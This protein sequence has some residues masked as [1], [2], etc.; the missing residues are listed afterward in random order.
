[1]TLPQISTVLQ[2]AVKIQRDCHCHTEKGVW[3][4]PNALAKILCNK[5]NNCLGG[6]SFQVHWSGQVQ[7]GEKGCDLYLGLVSPVRTFLPPQY[8]H[9]GEEPGTRTCLCYNIHTFCYSSSRAYTLHRFHLRYVVIIVVAVMMPQSPVFWSNDAVVVFASH[10]YRSWKGCSS[11][12]LPMTSASSSSQCSWRYS[13]AAQKLW[14]QAGEWPNFIKTLA[15]VWIQNLQW[16]RGST[17]EEEV[18]AIF[19]SLIFFF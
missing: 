19:F 2:G 12:P 17:A 14:V 13:N 16:D 4:T 6:S 11:T 5:K 15:E 8:F 3:V 10:S 9:E 18:S 7:R 1:M